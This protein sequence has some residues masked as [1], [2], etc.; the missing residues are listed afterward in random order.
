MTITAEQHPERAAA[1]PRARIGVALGS[2]SAR[3][4]A[5]IGVMEALAAAGVPLDVVCGSSVGALVGAA[6]VAGGLTPLKRWALDISWRDMVRLIDLRVASG[7]LLE[8]D[9]IVRV[10]EDMYGVRSIEDL[11]TP[12]SAVATELGTGQEVWLSAG[13]L[14]TALRASM[15]LPGLFSP[16]SI[17]GQQLVDGALVNP[18]PVSL[19]RAL[20]A[21][22]VIAI[23]LN[24]DRIGR[25]I[26]RRSA[27]RNDRSRTRAEF[28]DR[29][30]S[31]M[32]P[33]LRA[34]INWIANRVLGEA[35]YSPAYFD[36]IVGSINIMQ[37]QITRSRMA[38]HPPDIVIAPRLHGI[39]LL[40][41]NRA[42]E[43]IEE[44]RRAASRAL[45]QLRKLLERRSGARES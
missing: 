7:G 42:A 2:G 16:V 21:D 40:E 13:R 32:P 38:E 10:F 6:Y 37:D 26:A 5:H 11:A 28:L 34:G 3:G 39:G 33:G 24:S 36:V 23:N 4:W 31:E 45:P 12:F 27:R 15:A 30:S 25:R 14:A 20:G 44:G 8:G 22:V 1:L 18:V 17:R 41:F 9:R 29:M 43:A 19:C 35:G